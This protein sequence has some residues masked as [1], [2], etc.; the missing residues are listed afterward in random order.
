[1]ALSGL[2]LFDTTAFA[3]SPIPPNIDIVNRQSNDK[4]KLDRDT[5]ELADEYAELLLNLS[6]ITGNYQQYLQDYTDDVVKQYRPALDQFR[7]QLD[8]LRFVRDERLLAEQLRKHSEQ[9]HKAEIHIRDSKTIYP[10]RLY[11]LVQSLHRELTSLDDLLQDDIMPRLAENDKN[12]AAIQAHVTAVLHDANQTHADRDDLSEK[13]IEDSIM[14]SIDMTRAKVEA[15]RIAMLQKKI[16]MES[17]STGHGYVIVAPTPTAK[18]GATVKVPVPPAPPA[19]W[20]FGRMTPGSG[21]SREFADTVEA[22]SRNL[23]I[24]I[25]NR[26]GSIEVVGWTKE[27][28]TATWH[29][30]VAGASRLKERTFMDSAKLTI[31]RLSGNYVVVPIFSQPNDNNARL[32]VN[33]LV[34]Y[35]PS[36]NAVTIENVFGEIDAS[37]LEAGVTAATTY[38]DANFSNIRGPIAVTCSMGELMVSDC[39]GPLNLINS[40]APITVDGC[41]G[42]MTIQNAYTPVTVSDCRGILSITN[43]GGVTV[44]DHQGDLTIQ[45]SLGQ[46]EVT[47]LK[48]NLTATNR[49]QSIVVRDIDGNVKLDGAYSTLDLSNVQGKAYAINKFGSIRAEGLSGPLSINNDNGSTSVTLDDLLRG[50]SRITGNYGSILLTVPESANLLLLANS[51]GSIS[52]TLPMLLNNRENGSEGIIRLGKPAKDSL[53]V[54]SKNGSIVINSDR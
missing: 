18:P 30:E 12:R 52:T 6:E 13:A 4:P 3:Q 43:S 35:V 53:F 44:S 21:M 54:T 33:E 49:Y 36:R 14:A 47:G 11:R 48:G 5:R 23:P 24:K 22:V 10:M 16:K 50:T 25:E 17:K 45:N 19:A 20:P 1:M 37:E 2:L 41:T 9:L 39:E 29:I 26:Y 28:I 7:R 51:T 46:V 42:Q 15:K 34:V 38:A 40:Y 27:I 8:S 32:V 31:K